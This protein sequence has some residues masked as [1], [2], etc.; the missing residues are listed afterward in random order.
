MERKK[1][2]KYSA[3]GLGGLGLTGLGIRLSNPKSGTYTPYFANLNQ[4]LKDYKK[5]IPFLLVD[6]DV[7]DANLLELKKI[8]KDPKQFRIV[9]KSLPSPELIEYV[10][11]ATGTNRLMSFHQPFLSELSSKGDSSIDILMGKPMP[12]KTAA[13]YYD[14]L[15]TENGFDPSKQ[16][17]WL[18]DTELRIQEYIDLAKQK[19]IKLL[20]NFEI[21]VG[22]HRGGFDNL[23]ALAKALTLV[24]NNKEYVSFSGFMGYDAHIT[25][26]PSILLSREK[27]YRQMCDFYNACK[28]LVKTQFPLLYHE[29]LTF[30]GA[31]SPTLALHRQLDS[32][33]NDLSA[34]SFAVKPT[35]FDI[36]TLTSCKPACFIAS[37]VLKK[38]KDTTLP[39]IEGFKNILNLLDPNCEN[40]YYIYG[41]SWMANPYQPEGIKQSA[42]FGKSTNQVMFNASS[43]TLLNVGDYV[44]LRPHQSE[45]VF[46]Q[47]GGILGIR[48]GK[49]EKEWS[50]LKQDMIS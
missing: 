5:A 11:L 32:P 36:D 12:V 17:Q 41:G 28:N 42:L 47:F 18:V 14:T 10:K 43:N 34:G 3:L 31:G 6:L 9:V 24:E 13:Y 48:G 19:Q 26:V 21:D 44:F 33:L 45:S 46:L 4:T 37:P 38:Q 25:K 1:F 29:R 22:L 35:D 2:I 49:I 7:L 8:L 16:L 20:L 15:R 23:Q 39:S 30:N 27:A 50:V 40:S